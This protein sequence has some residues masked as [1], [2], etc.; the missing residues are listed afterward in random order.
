MRRIE[1]VCLL[2][3]MAALA[4]P[5]AARGEPSAGKPA[6]GWLPEAC[7][8]LLELAAAGG[9]GGGEESLEAR[10]N[11]SYR[12]GWAALESRDLETAERSLCQALDA[13]RFF[14]PRDLRFAE[15]LDELGLVHYLRGDDARAEVIQG[16]A[17]G[18]VLLALG[19]PASDLTPEQIDLCR[20]SVAT[21]LTRL[22]W[23]FDRQGRAGR[24]EA[25]LRR[26]YL[27]LAVGYI[28]PAALAGR[29]DWLISRYLLMEDVAAA[30]W[31]TGL[32]RRLQ[33]EE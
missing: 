11:R 12:Q 30:D 14:G 20:S 26:P 2:V 21:Y 15:T 5:L 31:L 33:Q 1:R 23:I 6:P 28:P 22:G 24:I 8:P 10:W 25:L 9:E 19:P 7:G 32:R 27:V 3:C 13:A 18:E 16:A 4:G 29:L 17:A